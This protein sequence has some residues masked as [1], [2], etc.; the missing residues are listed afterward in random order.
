[1][2]RTR[3]VLHLLATLFLLEN[4]FTLRF[5]D[6]TFQMIEEE[7]EKGDRKKTN[8][9]YLNKLNDEGFAVR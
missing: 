1:M 9:E 6:N 7:Y 3:A 5:N 4:S 8:E 2:K